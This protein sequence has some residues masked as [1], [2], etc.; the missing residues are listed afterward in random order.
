MASPAGRTLS[1]GRLTTCYA[2]LF[3]PEIV[4]I[5]P[6]GSPMQMVK[7]LDGIKKKSEEWN[8]MVEQVHRSEIGDQWLEATILHC[9]ENEPHL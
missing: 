9:P 3:S 8:K 2:E 5:E 6:E 1:S 7:G 4:S